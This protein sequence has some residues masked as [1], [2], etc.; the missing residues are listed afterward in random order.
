[1]AM[2]IKVSMSRS[3]F[4]SCPGLDDGYSLEL[5]AEKTRRMYKTGKR[6]RHKR[7]GRSTNPAGGGARG[8][9]MRE[10]VKGR[11]LDLSRE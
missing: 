3:Y 11:L 10:K 9:E 2:R 4:P 6:E 1:M 7:R 5:Q 8:I